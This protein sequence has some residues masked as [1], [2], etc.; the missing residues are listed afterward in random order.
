MR[1]L[2]FTCL[3]CTMAS[4]AHLLAAQQIPAF[5]LT[6][7]P[8]PYAVGVKVVEQYDD[9]RTFEATIDD[10]GKPF[11]GERARPLQTLIWYPAQKT[12]SLPMTFGDYAALRATETT[13]GHPRILT[14]VEG[15]L[16]DGMKP[17]FNQPLLAVR[18][19]TSVAGRFPVVIY[20]PSFSSVPWENVDICEYLAS[21]GYV[22]LAAPAMGVARDSTH[23]V[24]GTNEQARDISFLIGYAATLND[25]DLSKVA[26]AG[27]SWGGL[28]NLFAAARDNRIRALIAFDGSMRY[29][30][31]IVKQAGD[32]HPEEMTLPLLYFEGQNSLEDQARLVGNFHS[33]GPNVLNS[34]IHGDLIDI[35]MLGLVHPEFSAIAHRNERLWKYEFPGLQ[36]ADYGREDGKVGYGWVAKYS[37]IFLDAYLKQSADA[38]KFLH[39]TPAENNVPKH[40][41]AVHFRVAKPMPV[42]FDS[43]REQVGRE[44][45]DHVSEL[46]GKTQGE[47]PDFHLDAGTVA[48]WADDLLAESHFSEA[49]GVMQLDIHLDPSSRSYSNLA[50]AYLKAGNRQ[51]AIQNYKTALEKDSGNLI[52]KQSLEQLEN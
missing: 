18:D 11:L 39:N 7:K 47:Q 49:I 13:F 26:V 19:A 42:T 27:F 34:W 43:F 41:L 20:A 25:T 24:A 4:N 31:G 30:P 52:A 28:A 38:A 9:S 23:D 5:Q 40:V 37:L 36:E 35:K 22:V 21:H 46:Y 29:F 17:S 33:E 14:G 1:L 44:G 3:C 51:A 10:L 2:V 12:S 32:V 16:V 15:W 48:S 6:E 8:G 45:F 50:E